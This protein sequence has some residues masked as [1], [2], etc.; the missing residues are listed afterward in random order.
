MIIDVTVLKTNKSELIDIAEV[1]LI[2]TVVVEMIDIV[3]VEMINTAGVNIVNT[4]MVKLVEVEVEKDTHSSYEI[5]NGIVVA[6]GWTIWMGD[7]II[8][9]VE[10]FMHPSAVKTVVVLVQND[11]AKSK[12]LSPDAVLLGYNFYSCVQT[13]YS[14][15]YLVGTLTFDDFVHHIYNTSKCSSKL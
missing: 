10:I 1:K 12:I 4:T 13:I 6:F 5:E 3:E 14:I 8:E 15:L 7:F 2:N 11:P 9:L